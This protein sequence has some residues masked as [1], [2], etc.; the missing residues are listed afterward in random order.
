METDADHAAPA[1]AADGTLLVGTHEKGLYALS[2]DGTLRWNYV[3]D[4][5]IL[6]G[7]SIAMDGTIY[8]GSEHGL[9]ALR[10]TAPLANSPWPK[11]HHDLRNTG[12]VGG[13]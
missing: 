4:D 1:L 3:T 11:F 13:K 5:E 6:A 2:P 8:I 9:W 12:R 10:G 7:P